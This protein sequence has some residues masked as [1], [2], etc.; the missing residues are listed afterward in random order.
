MYTYRSRKILLIITFLILFL[1]FT[2]L[3][4]LQVLA[5]DY[6]PMK[7]KDAHIVKTGDTLRE[8]ALA[9]CTTTGEIVKANQIKDPD[10]IYPGQKIYIPLDKSNY[11]GSGW[12]FASMQIEGYM[13]GESH[14]IEGYEFVNDND[15]VGVWKNVATCPEISSFNKNIEQQQEYI[16]NHAGFIITFAEYGD[17]KNHGNFAWS[18]GIFYNYPDKKANSSYTIKAIDGYKYMFLEYNTNNNIFNNV[19]TLQSGYF[20]FRKAEKVHI[21]KPGDTLNK[22]AKAY[23]TTVKKIA[24]INDIDNVNYINVFQKL[25]LP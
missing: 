19:K 15:A 23:E 13:Q 17:I 5:S 2:L 25:I 18:K 10:L 6:D 11:L 1:C 16:K 9:Y 3:S 24:E 22:I 8:I 12:S 20:V 7:F 21:V 4:T 14:K